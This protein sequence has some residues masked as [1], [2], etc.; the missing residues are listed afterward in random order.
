MALWTL[1]WIGVAIWTAVQIGHLQRWSSAVDSTGDTVGQMASA[2]G[3]LNR[4]PR[5]GPE[6]GGAADQLRNLAAQAHYNAAQSRSAIEQLSYVIGIAVGIV[7]TVPALAALL[8]FR[9][10]RAR[11]RTA[12]VRAFRDEARR[13]IVVRYLAARARESL[14]YR[15]LL[16]VGALNDPLHEPTGDSLTRLAEAELSRLG[17]DPLASAAPRFRR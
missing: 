13:P 11:E 6:L 7:P 4:V 1:V 2:L 10:E 17:L 5:A 16:D 15:E 12:L 9:V 14:S 3:A 8:R